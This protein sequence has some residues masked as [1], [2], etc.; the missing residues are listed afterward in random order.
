MRFYDIPYPL[1]RDQL[2]ACAEPLTTVQ[3]RAAFETLTNILTKDT[4]KDTSSARNRFLIVKL[5][6]DAIAYSH[7]HVNPKVSQRVFWE[8]LFIKN[9][10][11]HED[12]KR[13]VVQNRMP[14]DPYKYLDAQACLK[15]LHQGGGRITSQPGDPHFTYA[16][17]QEAFFAVFGIDHD[18]EDKDRNPFKHYLKAGAYGDMLDEL[19]ALRNK[20]SHTNADFVDHMT[21]VLLKSDP[22][23]D[24]S[25]QSIPYYLNH[26]ALLLLPLCQTPWSGQADAR[27][28]YD[29]LWP[30]LHEQIGEIRYSV[31]KLLDKMSLPMDQQERIELL[32]TEAGVS[33]DQGLV[34]F[35]GDI[36]GF[37][38]ALF[39]AWT[40]A[41]PYSWEQGVKLLRNMLEQIRVKPVQHPVERD[42]EP[43]V[44]WDHLEYA[45]LLAN[46]DSRDSK[47]HYHLGMCYLLGKGVAPDSYQAYLEFKLAAKQGY[48]PAQV[49][50][51]R[52]YEARNSEPTDLQ[53]AFGWY[54]A[55][56]EQK[57]PDGLYHLGRCYRDEI[58]IKGKQNEAFIHFYVAAQAGHQDALLEVGIHYANLHEYG[59]A[60]PIL[61][62]MADDGSLRAMWALAKLYA[63][64]S[65]PCTDFAAAKELYWK[66]GQQGEIAA[67]TEYA[68]NPWVDI[69][70][71]ERFQWLQ[72]AT[73]GGNPEG[74]RQLA[75]CY[76]DGSGV[77]VDHA[78]AFTLLER[79]ANNG[80]QFAVL[81]MATCYATGFMAVE[82]MAQAKVWYE[83]ASDSPYAA[84][85]LRAIRHGETMRDD[86]ILWPEE[87]Y[88]I[89]TC[90]RELLDNALKSIRRGMIGERRKMD[91][92]Q[93]ALV[94]EL[95]Q[96]YEECY[97]ISRNLNHN[98]EERIMQEA[99]GNLARMFRQ[100]RQ[101]G[102]D[103]E[104]AMD[105]YKE[106]ADFG[107]EKAM[108]ALIRLQEREFVY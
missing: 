43:Q 13:G 96:L 22:S 104:L 55:A 1:S 93:A 68:T 35:C 70:P 108:R 107:L 27:W 74:Q 9:I 83:K 91:W 38:Y 6:R 101:E 32:L 66:L 45:Q 5:L 24:K 25:P 26:I 86:D 98:V 16:L 71:Q 106:A 61:Q 12:A 23:D 81:D 51:G 40:T 105:L 103:L 2:Y 65:I 77:Q 53:D 15:Y 79:A 78:K 90:E 17:D 4:D 60:I 92:Q 87:R 33:V 63:T 97:E 20:N 76:R 94:Y 75:Y 39:F 48:A 57:D 85:M 64:P 88:Q 89:C 95:A 59:K 8:N 58:V 82:D 44:D 49:A 50:L 100:M 52:W 29:N 69:D 102:R 14:T 28:L 80:N 10:I 19:I 62:P 41:V 34:S 84:A 67:Y 56:A 31:K 21:M 7:G 30:K 11:L 73:D 3:K 37:A 54:Q 18:Y 72:L 36:V 42:A 99:N 47:C 46:K